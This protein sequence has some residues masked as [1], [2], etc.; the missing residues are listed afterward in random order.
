MI[1]L[2]DQNTFAIWLKQRSALKHDLTGLSCLG[3]PRETGQRGQRGLRAVV[4]GK[5]FYMAQTVRLQA[6]PERVIG[7][8]LRHFDPD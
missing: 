6:L 2:Q 3:R 7:Q 1:E 5:G 8:G 4:P